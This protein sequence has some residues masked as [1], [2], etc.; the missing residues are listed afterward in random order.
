MIKVKD[1]SEEYKHM[2]ENKCDCEGEFIPIEQSLQ[3][4]DGI[5]VDV[6]NT[7]CK[8]CGANKEFVFDISS[9]YDPFKSFIKDKTK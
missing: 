1:I 8:K 3:N 7:F 5:F 6:H 9:F 2:K 4:R